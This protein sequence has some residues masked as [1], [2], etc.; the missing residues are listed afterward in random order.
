MG[1]NL[2]SGNNISVALNQRGT[3][4]EHCLM[5]LRRYLR[6]L[7]VGVRLVYDILF[8]SVVSVLLMEET[9]DAQFV[10]VVRFLYFVSTEN[11]LTLYHFHQAMGCDKAGIIERASLNLFRLPAIK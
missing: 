3:A 1:S 4:H 2:V 7:T 5:Y 8:T 11:S 6:F 10:R 9:L